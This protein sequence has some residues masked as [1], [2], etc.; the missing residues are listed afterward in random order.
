VPREL[1]V[2]EPGRGVADDGH[3]LEEDDEGVGGKP[4]KQFML[5]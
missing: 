5:R 1:K 2:E 4:G 3:V